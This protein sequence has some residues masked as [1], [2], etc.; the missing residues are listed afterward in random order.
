MDHAVPCVPGVVDD[1]VD[2]AVAK[3]GG[4]FDELGEV[5]GVGYVAGDSDGAVRVRVIDCSGDFITLFCT[6]GS[7][8]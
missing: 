2:L 5:G 3:V 8:C 1:D 7:E 6:G 4:C